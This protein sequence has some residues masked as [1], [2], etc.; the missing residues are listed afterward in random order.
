MKS[1][2]PEEKQLF[3]LL[4]QDRKE[5]AKVLDKPSMRGVERSVT[6]KYTDTAHFVYEVLQNADDVGATRVQ[7]TL[8]RDELVFRHNGKIRFTISNVEQESNDEAN[9]QLGHINAITSIG[10]SNKTENE[11]GKFGVGFKAVF[12]YTDNP[13]I[14]DDFWFKIEDF[15]V[16]VLLD[17]DYPDR[18]STETVFRFP[19]DKNNKPKEQC[20]NE[21][22]EKLENLHNPILFLKNLKSVE[23]KIRRNKGSYEKE[24]LNQKEL[25][26]I[27]FQEVKISKRTQYNNASQRIFIFTQKIAHFPHHC[28]IAYR[29]DKN[30]QLQYN[31]RIPAYCFFETQ[32]TTNLK[33]F[34]HAP[35]LLTDSRAGILES[36]NWNKKVIQQLAQLTAS[37]LPIF[38]SLR[39]INDDFFNALPIN[40]TDFYDDS[41]NANNK[42]SPIYDAVLKKLKTEELLPVE[43]GR[44]FTTSENAYLAEDIQ[45]SIGLFS[46]KFLASFTEN[47]NSQWIFIN[48]TNRQKPILWQYIKENLVQATLDSKAISGSITKSLIAKQS[49]EWLQN[50]YSYCLD[51]SSLWNTLKTKP[52][53]RLEDD[54]IISLYSIYGDLQVYLPTEG[55]KAEGI[56]F[57]KKC[58]IEDKKSL[59]FLKKLGI[60]KPD[61]KALI[62][63]IIDKYEKKIH[64]QGIRDWEIFRD[65]FTSIFNYYSKDL[66]NVDTE[67]FIGRL[68]NIH[69][70][71]INRF[72]NNEG[73]SLGNCYTYF[74]NDELQRYFQDL[75]ISIN[76]LEEKFYRDLCKKYSQERIEDFLA[77]LGVNR[78]PIFEKLVQTNPSPSE[79]FELAKKEI[80]YTQGRTVKVS[81]IALDGLKEFLLVLEEHKLRDKDFQKLREKSITLWNLLRKI[82]SDSKFHRDRIYGRVEYFY[83]RP[84]TDKFTAQWIKLL[85]ETQWLIDKQNG[86]YKPSEITVED[87][88]RD[89]ILDDSEQLIAILE[90]RESNSTFPSNSE[91]DELLTPEER[92]AQ[93]I[94][95]SILLI[96][97]QNP[98]LTEED[99]LNLIKNSLPKPNPIQSNNA[100][101]PVLI[102]TNRQN[103]SD[104]KIG[105]VESEET[106]HSE[107]ILTSQRSKIFTG[108][109]NSQKKNERTESNETDSDEYTPLLTN[110]EEE[111]QKSSESK[112]K[113]EA[114]WN[115]AEAKSQQVEEL[116]QILTKVEQ[117][118]FAWFKALLE[119]ECYAAAENRAKT[120]P[121]QVKFYQIE[122]DRE[123]QE[124]L[125]LSNTSYIPYN[126]EDS[127]ELSLKLNFKNKYIKPVNVEAVSFQKKKLKAKLKYPKSLIDTDLTEIENAVLEVKN[128]DFILE[129]LKN[130]FEQLN[131][132]DNFNLKNNLP[133]QIQFIFG[134]PGTG[135]TTHLARKEIIPR[136][137][138]KDLKILVLTP[139]NKAADVLTEKI[140]AECEFDNDLSFYQWLIRYGETKSSE[141]ENKVYRKDK[142]FEASVF[143]KIVLVT[144][145]ARFSYD[146]FTI[147]NKNKSED[148]WTF[149]IK[150]FDWDYIIFDEASMISLASIIY[151]IYY[152]TQRTPV[153][154]QFIVGGDPFQI[155]PIIRVEHKGWKDGNIYTLVELHKEGSFEKPQTKPHKFNVQNLTT[156]YRS[157]LSIGT[158]FSEF[159]YGGILEHYRSNDKVKPIVVNQLSLKP[160][161][162]IPFKVSHFESIYKPRKVKRS[163]YQIYST[164]F[165]VELVNYIS[166]QISNC[167]FKI[168]VVCPYRIQ[169]DIIDK[170]IIKSNKLS[171]AEIITGTIHGFQGDECNLIVSVF[172]PPLGISSNPKIFLNNKNILNVA[173]SRAK[174]YLILLVPYDD[175]HNLKTE[176]L[177]HLEKIKSLIKENPSIC[178]DYREYKDIEIEDIIFGQE[179][180]IEELA[181]STSHQTVNV[182]SDPDQKYE[183]RYDENAVDIQLK[184]F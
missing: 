77:K 162:I 48:I 156:Q 10:Q 88:S 169:A 86:L 103:L 80:K 35:F 96:L 49:D 122:W 175:T 97:Q 59:E 37:S 128:A 121:I 44:S 63:L 17:D 119:L 15:I 155:S 30:H 95:Q 27:F 46:Q 60:E 179:R 115:E 152:T 18:E 85:R 21:I 58:F 28:S 84:K 142:Y 174:D 93:T 6:E 42:F 61:S 171:Q 116:E 1:L 64:I 19:F 65:D 109:T 110:I 43:D 32:E 40:K 123:S 131:L 132:D 154:C 165:T 104:N 72:S 55:I 102:N 184:L 62:N 167:D 23:W 92:K 90:F 138:E 51:R 52:I 145:I 133:E 47:L 136:I 127:G 177:Y 7:F 89:Y 98:S 158:L 148:D 66:R 112:D 130:V 151:A 105:Q 94:G 141:T 149:P 26:E 57:V 173:I 50:F 139:T 16:P 83:R 159:S 87:L 126:I 140:I 11:I 9:Q 163:P 78:F 176:Q 172:N 99:I 82:S 33:F 75:P 120:N 73:Y 79:L 56:K 38:K 81:D 135:K 117:Y 31:Q 91:L 34:V 2:N 168:G 25:S 13:H 107:K 67:N 113:A 54:T 4:H 108:L 147:E 3:D 22:K 41:G 125:V 166:S 114:A 181:F 170:L 8:K 150:K 24:V 45:K 20:Y 129:S 29:V 53:I 144:T 74:P 164:I 36:Q 68:K 124:V 183:V 69:F 143:S 106:H 182:Y 180:K 71:I 100:N 70:Y 101:E 12:Q 160:I 153:N 178:K 14:Y 111:K 39:L 5:N 157:I 146:Q 137:R 118:S 76:W 161:T 134:P